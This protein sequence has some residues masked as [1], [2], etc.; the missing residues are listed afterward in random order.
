M[1]RQG[2]PSSFYRGEDRPLEAGVLQGPQ[3]VG[4]ERASNSELNDASHGK[5]P[6]CSAASHAVLNPKEWPRVSLPPSSSA[7]SSLSLNTCLQKLFPGPPFKAVHQSSSHALSCLSFFFAAIALIFSHEF[8]VYSSPTMRL[9]APR[10]VSLLH[11]PM[12][13]VTGWAFNTE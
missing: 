10:L 8:V 1:S 6:A 13:R 12:G 9:Q 11:S 3:I 7:F 4:E 2:S 5:H